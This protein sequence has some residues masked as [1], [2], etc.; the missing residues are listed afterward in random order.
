MRPRYPITVKPGSWVRVCFH[1]KRTDEVGAPPLVPARLSKPLRV[2]AVNS[3]AVRIG[4][5]TMNQGS[6]HKSW[7]K[8]EKPT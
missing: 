8:S 5:D 6:W 4:G 7:V 1:A 2:F 3:N